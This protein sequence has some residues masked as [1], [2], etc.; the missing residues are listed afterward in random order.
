MNRPAFILPEAAQ[1]AVGAKNPGSRLRPQ[2]WLGIRKEFL[3]PLNEAPTG[4]ILWAACADGV[5]RSE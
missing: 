2:A 1:G 3:R 5:T 4:E